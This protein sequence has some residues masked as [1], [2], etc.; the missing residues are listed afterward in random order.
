MSS[1]SS[2]PLAEG[3]CINYCHKLLQPQGRRNIKL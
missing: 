1:V 2:C 3:A